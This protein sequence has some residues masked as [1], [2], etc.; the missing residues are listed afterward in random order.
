MCSPVSWPLGATN[1]MAVTA[2][3]ATAATRAVR[4]GDP[5]VT[6]RDSTS[7]AEGDADLQHHPRDEDHAPDAGGC[8]ERPGGLGDAEAGEGH[9]A[10]REGEPQRLD[11]RVGERADDHR[12]PHR[13]IVVGALRA[14]TVSSATPCHPANTTLAAM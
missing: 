13:P 5:R 2:S 14:G 6:R 11:E 3:G 4:P 10:E 8:G 1:A 7:G 12:P 9:S